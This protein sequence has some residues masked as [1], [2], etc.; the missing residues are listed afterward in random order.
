MYHVYL[1]CVPLLSNS[2]VVSPRCWYKR[3]ES[4]FVQIISTLKLI[5]LLIEKKRHE[6][7]KAVYKSDE[8]RMFLAQQILYVKKKCL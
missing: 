8:R 5:P 7:L 6:L 1:H 4:Y 2:F 3:V